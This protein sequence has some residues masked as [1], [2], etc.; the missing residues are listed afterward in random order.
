MQLRCTRQGTIS[1]Y[2]GTRRR[3]KICQGKSTTGKNPD[4]PQ[5]PG[6][7]HDQEKAKRETRMMEATLKPIRLQNRVLDRERR[8]QTRWPDQRTGLPTRTRRRTKHT[9]GT[10]PPTTMILRRHQN[11]IYRTLQH[12]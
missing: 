11:R 12:T 10:N 6:T 2:T 7:V 9:N 5:K 3:E 4:R 1:D 8:R